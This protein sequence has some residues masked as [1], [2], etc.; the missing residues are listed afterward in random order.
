[1]EQFR[2]LFTTSAMG[3]S[4]QELPA[5][6]FSGL[7]VVPD[8][9]YPA[10]PIETISPELWS[11]ALNVKIFHTIATTQA[12]LRIVREHKARLL[13]LTPGIVA[14]L[15]PPFHSVESTVVRA[16]EGFTMS[17]T[18][19]MSTQGV[20]VCQFKLGSFESG[21]FESRSQ[22][23][24]SER[25][26]VHSWPTATHAAYADNNVNHRSER[27]D[28]GLVSGNKARSKGSSLRELNNAVFDALTQV[29]PRR[30]W[31]VGKG[32]VLYDVVGRLVPPGIVGWMTG[33]RMKPAGAT[34]LNQGQLVVAKNA[35]SSMTGSGQWEKVERIS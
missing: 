31:R 9:I 26:E 15:L 23:K 20:H 29:H 14:S 7:I 32:S 24:S 5:L 21:H 10:G 18:A 33:M 4:G 12:F 11:D 16:L 35:H 27:D 17:L 34:A 28:L 2:S 13:V 30:T 22:V 6:T 25:A 19:E 8:V 1:M 3:A